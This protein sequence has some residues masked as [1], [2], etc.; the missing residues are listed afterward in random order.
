MKA[1]VSAS[2]WLRLTTTRHTSADGEDADAV[3]DGVVVA[4]EVADADVVEDAV[5]DAVEV[6]DED[7]DAVAIALVSSPR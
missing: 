1:W 4:D 2:R 3:S 5:E 7:T 6:A